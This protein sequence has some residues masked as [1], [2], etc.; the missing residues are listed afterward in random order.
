M[1]LIRRHVSSL[2][3][4]AAA[5]VVAFP[6]AGAAFASPAPG[7]KLAQLKV[8]GA[9]SAYGGAVAISGSTAVVG[10][11]NFPA[12]RGKVYVF[13]RTA[14][15]WKR[16]ATLTGPPTAF[17]DDFGDAVAISGS[18]IAVGDDFTSTGD[19]LGRVYIYAHTSTGW[20]QA[21]VFSNRQDRYGLEIPRAAQPG[22][23]RDRSWQPR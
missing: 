15:G 19:R 16:S 8:S 21:A 7:T 6:G 9:D 14:T 23:Q 13:T 1:V 22:P 4:A 5:V 12:S 3:A 20:K 17:G 18:T 2:A 11:D 10:E